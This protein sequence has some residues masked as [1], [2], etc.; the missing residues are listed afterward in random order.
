M[1]ELMNGSFTTRMCKED[2]CF[3]AING[4]VIYGFT[5]SEPCNRVSVLWNV[6]EYLN[7]CLF[8][9]YLWFNKIMKEERAWACRLLWEA[10]GKSKYFK[11]VLKC[12]Q[13]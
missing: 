9:E 5:C 7:L 8:L 10:A 11:K 2:V 12:F 3:K 13:L 4:I 1:N 6:T